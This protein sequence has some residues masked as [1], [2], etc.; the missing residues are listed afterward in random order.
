MNIGKVIR[1]HR[2]E[3][4]E[5]PLPLRKENDAPASPAPLKREEPALEPTNK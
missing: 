5:K 2:V 4:I 1:R 3:P